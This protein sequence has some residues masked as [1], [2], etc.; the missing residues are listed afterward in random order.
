M[1]FDVN[2]PYF[3]N[4]VLTASPEQLRM[5]LLEGCLR[6]MRDG[7]EGLVAKDYERMYEGFSQARDIVL[8]LVN[9]MR[10]EVA[11]D[12]CEKVRAVLLFVYRRLV[13]GGFEKNV[14][15]VDECIRLMEYERDTWRLLMEQLASERSAGAEPA[16]VE[17]PTAIGPAGDAVGSTPSTPTSPPAP[18]RGTGTYGPPAGYGNA[19]GSQRPPMSFSA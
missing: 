6:F 3:R 7:R 2:N 17:A 19:A 10:P 9:G 13:E 8:E 15:A 11:P 16:T 18:A 5:L 1:A 14:D 4:Q 12:L